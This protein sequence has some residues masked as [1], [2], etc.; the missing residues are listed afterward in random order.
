MTTTRTRPHGAPTLD[1]AEIARRV[2]AVP[3]WYHVLDLGAGVTTPGWFDLRPI[4]DRIPFP[5]VRGRRCLD[6]GTYDGFFAFE[7]ERRGAAEVVA[8][9]ILDHASWDWPWHLRRVG[10]ERLA[11]LVGP[12]KGVGFV[13]ARELLG[14][15]VERR[16]VSVYDLS[17]QTVG[18]FDVV[19]C[20]SLLL[21][22]RDPLRALEAVRSVCTGYFLSMETVDLVTTVV[23]RRR[24]LLR[25]YGTDEL[26]LW[27]VPN[28]AGHR[29]MLEASGF[30][31][32]AAS[33][34]YTIPYGPAHPRPDGSWRTRARLALQRVMAGPP[35][36]PHVAVLARPR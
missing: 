29:R 14:S 22:L 20:G 26:C 34:P 24:P 28:I 5:E 31:V 36:V 18:T 35:G 12:E 21:H 6:V 10:G 19:V 16:I 11:A 1:P 4:L 8:T 27:L 15:A 25:L 7:L 13:V 9:D 23:G 33:R 30:E 3:S 32:I 17:P 2:A